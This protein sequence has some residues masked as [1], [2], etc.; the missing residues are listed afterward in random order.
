MELSELISAAGMLRTSA[1]LVA[2]LDVSD[3][4][5]WAKQLD[6]VVEKSLNKPEKE[7]NLTEVDLAELAELDSEENAVDTAVAEI[8]GAILKLEEGERKFM[9]TAPCMLTC[10][11]R[12]GE[13]SKVQHVGGEEFRLAG[14][15]LGKRRAL[16]YQF[17]PLHPASYAVMEMNETEAKANMSGF[18]KWSSAVGFQGMIREAKRLASR[19]DE[20]AKNKGKDEQYGADWGAF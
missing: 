16:I 7:V 2:D 15:Y 18:G 6:K 19:Q 17:I 10:K 5:A 12:T 8:N 3:L 11:K 9:L 1:G 20:Q 14:A 4:P 13:F